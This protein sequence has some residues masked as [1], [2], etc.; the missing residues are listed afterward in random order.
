MKYI[1]IT[2]KHHDGF[3]LFDTKATDY[4]MV[5]ATP[6]GKDLLKQ[7]A[8]ECRKQGIKFCTYHSIMDWHHPAQIAAA[9]QQLQ[10]DQDR[11]GRKA[12]YVDYMKQQLKELIDN[13]DAGGALV[14]RRVAA[15]GAPRRTA[16]TFTPICASSSRS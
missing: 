10:P 4:D 9:T 8:D 11:A 3:C 7:L 12:E 14:R 5:D 16:A 13:Y 1:V 6:Y 15:T 2:T